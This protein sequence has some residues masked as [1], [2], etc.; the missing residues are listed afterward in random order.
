MGQNPFFLVKAFPI[1]NVLLGAIFLSLK[2][3][4]STYGD[5]S[6]ADIVR[7]RVDQYQ[8][9]GGRSKV[10]TRNPRNGGAAY[11][12]II[13]TRVPKFGGGDFFVTSVFL[14]RVLSCSCKQ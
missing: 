6:I 1:S 3:E 12:T 11:P 9:S 8:F 4:T 5:A 10:E 13:G 7:S 2:I 14:E